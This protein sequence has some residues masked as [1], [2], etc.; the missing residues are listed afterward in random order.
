MEETPTVPAPAE[1]A[2]KPM[3]FTEK[4]TDIFSSPG[5]LFDNVRDTPPTASNWLVPLLIFVV[6][7]FAMSQVMMHNPSLL[8]QLKDQIHQNM[9]K[10]FQEAIQQGKM[11]PEQADQAR[12]QAEAF[13]NPASPIFVAFQAGALIVMTPIALFVISLLYWLLGKSIIKAQAPYMK[14]VEVV[15]LVFFITILESIVTTIMV[16]GLDSLHA[17]PSLALAVLGSF[18]TDNKLHVALS[19]INAFTIWNLVVVSIGLGHLFRRDVPKVM[20]LVFALWI[21]WVVFT[22]LTGINFT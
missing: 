12:Q 5:E 17:S 3:S 6:V 10:K 14:V 4:I 16:I 8:D 15:G 2:I 19:K 21:L 9:E 7:A 22:L 18:S 13:S 20:A 11:T 1:A